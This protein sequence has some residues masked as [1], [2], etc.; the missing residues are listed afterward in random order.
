MRLFVAVSLPEVIK[1]R[2]KK[3]T[4]ILNKYEGIKTVETKNLHLNLEFLGKKKKPDKIIRDLKDITFQ[5]F[6][7]K[8]KQYGFFP[9]QNYIK[10]IWLGIEENHELEKL[11]EKVSKLTK[12]NKKYIPHITL[13]RVKKINEK[14]KKQ[15]LKELQQNLV[16]KTS[17]EVKDFKLYQSKLTTIGPIYNVIQKFPANS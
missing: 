15:L 12:N 3:V 16:P 1:N 13:A 14:Q 9:S 5:P 10:V 8:T 2:L 7:L 6:I 4:T 17:V 11:Q